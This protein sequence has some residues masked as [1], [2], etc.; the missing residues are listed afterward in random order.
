M[1]LNGQ[2]LGYLTG[3]NNSWSINSWPLSPSHL[4]NGTNTIFIDT[5]APG[6]GCWCVGV[7][8]IEVKAKVGFTVQEHTPL[9]DEKNRDFHADKL[10]LTVT[11]SKE[12][13]SSTLTSDTFKLEYRDAAG[14]WQQVAGSFSQLAPEK[15]R[16]IPAA[17]LE[18]GVPYP[19]TVKGGPS[20]VKRPGAGELASDEVWYFETVPDLSLTDG[21]DYGSGSVCAPSTAPCPGLEL[22]V[23]QVARNAPMV[24][25]GKSAVARL[26]LRWKPH[27][28]IHPDDQVLELDVNASV[29]V[30][31]A[32][33]SATQKVKRPDGYTAAERE[34]AGHTI[35]I[36]HTPSSA[37]DYA[38]EVMPLPQSNAVPV[39]YTQS[40]SL[41]SSGSSP[42]ISFNHYFIQDGI[43]SSGVPATDED[44]GLNT[45]TAG[46]GFITDT[47]PV[48]G[49][50]FNP[51]GNLS[52][53]GYAF[54]GASTTGLC[55]TQQTVACPNATGTSFTNKS[56]MLCV[57][58]KL[59][60]L[61]GTNKF[62]AATV[63][64]TLCPNATAFSLGNKVV[65]HQ[66]GQGANDAVIAHEVGHIY[67]ISSANNPTASH[68]DD[69]TNVEGFQ[70][71]TGINRSYVENAS[72]AVSLMHTT[73]QAT[74]TQWID[75]SDY[76][77]LLAS[78]T[79]LAGASP[80]AATSAT[81]PYLFVSGFSDMET[82]V[83]ELEPSFLQEH[84]Q[85]AGS[86]S[87][88]C[89]VELL[90]GAGNVLAG[91]GVTPGLELTLSLKSGATVHATTGFPGGEWGP[92]PFEVSLPW[93]E[94]ARRLQVGCQGIIL[95][96]RERSA[97]P[98]AVDFLD[99][100]PG[101]SL[102]GVQYLDWVG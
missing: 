15:F 34:L 39:R 81:G 45:L 9:A 22:A 98:P 67:G 95:F 5:D 50:T 28:D 72:K 14:A 62:V 26:Y 92:Q 65:M 46:V 3:A 44:E 38:V 10:D 82:G 35:N 97:Y 57:Y 27:A 12:Y 88:T 11:F 21:F 20:G 52:P 94:A 59:K 32:T 75:N 76:A 25:G 86:T 89:R 60:T 79:S 54:T 85:D 96:S 42:S 24:P 36:P 56:E 78:V 93:N 7:G 63:P 30:D 73:T 40:A 61:L 31:G 58:N 23:F 83:V 33:H 18:D 84:S 16:F 53:I 71:S 64:N 77:D 47:F 91:A 41:G 6:T 74:G 29:T 99:L 17:N 37:F 13:D 100:A 66:T 101:A 8:Y 68:R 51:Q 69:S 49:T 19:A 90:D 48:L 4:V 1:S 70:V 87:G 102:S 55:G 80:V 2:S 43:W